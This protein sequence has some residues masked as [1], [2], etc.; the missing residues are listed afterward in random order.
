METEASLEKMEVS[1]FQHEDLHFHKYNF[2]QLFIITQLII[3][4]LNIFF[5]RTRYFQ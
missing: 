5:I 4:L 1:V 3:R 2:Y